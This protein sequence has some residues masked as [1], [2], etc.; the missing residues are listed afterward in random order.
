MRIIHVTDVYND[1]EGLAK[2]LESAQE[3]EADVFACTGDLLGACLTKEEAQTLDAVYNFIRLN[4]QVKGNFSF[5]NIL[6]HIVSNKEMPEKFREA[7]Q[8]YKSL[9]CA[10]D[11]RAENQ[12]K[13]MSDL[14]KQY[15]GEVL[16]VP[17]NRD[18]PKFFDYFGM[19]NIHNRFAVIN[20]VK[21]A[22]YGG[23]ND[24][25]LSHPASRFLQFS[26]EE[27]YHFLLREDSDV[28][29]T[30]L[31]PYSVGDLLVFQ[32]G[33][34]HLGS[35][36]LLSYIRAESPNLLLCGHSGART[37]C[38]DGNYSTTFVENP[39]TFGNFGDNKLS[40]TFSE[41][42]LDENKY[43]SIARLHQVQGEQIV[44]IGEVKATV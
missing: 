19:K 42:E 30:H 36:A 27:M 22:G 34:K 6:D 11:E 37:A 4:V 23:S 41:I 7:A 43:V 10:F 3:K 26:E 17:G 8:T 2:V 20:G 5:Q 44:L 28:V 25:H 12:Y 35:F 13:G 32:G 24:R 16:M 9:E 39:G 14:F 31:P 18:S 15:P 21:F 33:K 38:T 29:M 1:Q 40:S